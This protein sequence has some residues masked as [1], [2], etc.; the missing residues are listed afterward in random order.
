[1]YFLFKNIVF[2]LQWSFGVSM[3]E[4]GGSAIMESL[5]HCSVNGAQVGKNGK[6]REDVFKSMRGVKRGK[7]EEK[8]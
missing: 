8:V 2:R 6:M 5:D 4:G 3:M 7:H 1:M